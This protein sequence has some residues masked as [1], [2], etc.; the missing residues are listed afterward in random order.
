MNVDISYE[1]QRKCG[2]RSPGA[3]GVG[4]YLRGFGPG[5]DC[6]RLPFVLDACPCCGAGIKPSRGFTWIDPAVIFANT[7]TPHC[8]HFW[9]IGIDAGYKGDR[10]HKHHLCWVCNP[11]TAG[12]RAGLI[13]VGEKFYPTPQAFMRE[14]H[15]MG[16]SRKI[17]AL[18]NGFEVGKTVIYLAHSKLVAEN[19]PD[20]HPT[21]KG[22]V[23]MVFR[24][25]LVELV[26][27]DPNRVP[28]K[29]IELAKRI[30]EDKCRLIK[31][32]RDDEEVEEEAFGTWAEE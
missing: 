4:I 10:H 13:W 7:I 3:D 26:I 1:R 24:P 9:D 27:D 21:W 12:H 5:E 15:E 11:E 8:T 31:V 30:G 16:I 18:P 14:A 17:G 22:G 25:S 23:F 29:A 32:I 20:N 6:E 28:D 2:Y 19:G